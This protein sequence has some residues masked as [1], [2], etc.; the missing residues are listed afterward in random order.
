MNDEPPTETTL[1]AQVER[2]C[3]L[4][5]LVDALTYIAVW[6]TERAVA[7]AERNRDKPYSEWGTSHGGRWDTCFKL[8]FA[9]VMDRWTS[10]LM[11]ESDYIHVRIL[12]ELMSAAQHMREA[13]S[14]GTLENDEELK[15][16]IAVIAARRDTRFK[17]LAELREG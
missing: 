13:L 11:R 3:Q 5:T 12:S 16:A 4:P 2:A 15:S 14:Y 6:E 7:Q 9:A 10:R 1:Q 17:D 8:C